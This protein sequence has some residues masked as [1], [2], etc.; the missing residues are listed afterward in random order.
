M[1]RFGPPEAL[2]PIFET[3]GAFRTA[4]QAD[5]K[6]LTFLPTRGQCPCRRLRPPL[7]GGH[8]CAPCGPVL[9]SRAGA[10]VPGREHRCATSRRRPPQAAHTPL[11]PPGNGAGTPAP[12]LCPRA[13][14]GYFARPRFE[15]RQPKGV[16][17]NTLHRSSAKHLHFAR[18][19]KN[20]CPHLGGYPRILTTFVTASIENAQPGGTLGTRPPDNT[21]T[22]HEE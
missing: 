8:R 4:T 9:L 16:S 6:I 11:P 7:P 10:G 18:P 20:R 17:G 21:P 1:R 22:R 15:V 2:L 5:T 3:P 13:G 12:P 19:P 14:T